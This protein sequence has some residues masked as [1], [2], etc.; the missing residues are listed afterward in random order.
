MRL[1]LPC[2]TRVSVSFETLLRSPPPLSPPPHKKK[3]ELF[4]TCAEAE[5]SP[6]E[7]MNRLRTTHAGAA[8][9]VIILCGVTEMSDSTADWSESSLEETRAASFAFCSSR[10]LPFCF[11]TQ[12]SKYIFSAYVS[13]Q[14]LG[15][16][17]PPPPPF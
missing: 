1:R 6:R 15:R 9:T 13:S 8:P 11:S 14:C 5:L 17:S 7:E 4:N 3:N 10:R 16:S 2:R 12:N